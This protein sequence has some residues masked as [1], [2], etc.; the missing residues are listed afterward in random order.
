MVKKRNNA[1]SADSRDWFGLSSWLVVGVSVVLG[2]AILFLALRGAERERI[3]MGEALVNRADALIWALVAGTRTWLG[4]EG[5]RNIV[6]LLVEETA[7]QPGVVYLAVIA[8]DGEILAHSDPALV[9][10]RMD[11][12]PAG[13][14]AGALDWRRVDDDAALFR[15]FRPFAP[16]TD[17]G[18]EHGPHHGRRG[19]EMGGRNRMA[20]PAR[21]ERLIV[22]AGE[23]QNLAVVGLDRQPFVEALRADFRQTVISALIAAAL[24]MAGFISM[25]WAHHYRRSR[26]LLQDARAKAAEVVACL[27]L[28]LITSDTDRNIEMINAAA[29]TM[30]GVDPG[31]VV[32]APL[33]RLPALDWRAVESE[34]DRGG[35]VLERELALETGPGGRDAPVR[36]SASQI[37]GENGAALGHVF[38]LGDLGE[39][40][41]LQDEVRR[42]QRLTALGNLAAG[43]A[44]E[45]RNPLS[46]IK[47]MATFMA[48]KLP[49]GGAEEEAGKTMLE[50]VDRLNGV[51]SELLEFARKG[52]PRRT[53]TDIETLMRRALRL[54]GAD[55]VDKAIAVECD[56]SPNLPEA[57][58]DHER[59]TQALLNI[60]LN[61]V[62]AMRPGGTLRLAARL[63][64]DGDQAVM[65]VADDG[66]GISDQVRETM[67]NPY[68]T[69]K[70]GGVGLG[71]ALVQQAVENHN[72]SIT[73]R[74]RPGEGTEFVIR[75]PLARGGAIAPNGRETQSIL[76]EKG[77]DGAGQTDYSH[78]G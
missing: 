19:M 71:L 45:I 77:G 74:S 69:T 63:S 56:F 78:R 58:L 10:G 25:F 59:F 62:Q 40:R 22:G 68:F 64:G 17:S 1:G 2:I 32:G 48:G 27:P 65:T 18:R 20:Q 43:V 5:D 35:Q 55:L 44:H 21:S 47:G 73:V 38:I 36:L 66:E 15:V 53:P 67:F 34:L 30:F 24:G 9:G 4:Y 49:K 41:R 8:P 76:N 46:T 3:R 57:A 52:T 42:N 50:E 23:P 70:P 13:S 28:G 11:N 7:R 51:V 26:R 12:V 61:A 31:S 6:Q 54:A 14:E 75:V 29:A 39:V 60:I 37:R 16:L 33:D 72:G